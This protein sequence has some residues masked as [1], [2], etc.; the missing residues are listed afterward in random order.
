MTSLIHVQQIA[1]FQ[2]SRS[3][4]AFASKKYRIDKQLQ[5]LKNNKN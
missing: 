4:A 1:N 3:T 2:E 5:K